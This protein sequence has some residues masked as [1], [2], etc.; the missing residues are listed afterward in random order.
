MDDS[1]DIVIVNDKPE[2]L[3]RD[4]GESVPASSYVVV[5]DTTTAKL[6][7]D[8]L[9]ESFSARG[10]SVTQVVVQPG[11]QSKSLSVTEE[12]LT[13]FHKQGLDR[14]SCVL[15]VGGGVVGDLAGFA[16]GCFMRG[17]KYVQIPT[18]LLSQVDSSVGGKVAVNIP[19]GKNYCGMFLQPQKVYIDIAHLQTLPDQIFLEGL[20]EV[21]K[22][23]FISGDGLY[24]YLLENTRPIL[25]RNPATMTEVVKRCCTIKARIVEKDEQEA[26]KR[27]VLNYGHTFGHAIEAAT[28][29]TVA[30]GVAVAYGMRAAANAAKSWG[31]FSDSDYARH[32]R[33]LDALGLAT[34]PLDFNPT[35]AHAMLCKDKKSVQGNPRFIL[36]TS[37]GSTRIVTNL[38]NTLALESLAMLAGQEPPMQ[39]A[40]ETS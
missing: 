36:P 27:M 26:G 23:A 7:G 9:V 35:Q 17:I 12:V 18:T 13:Q 32:E 39:N 40:K 5:C 33:L 20:G 30:H 29:Y 3:V 19:Q 11:E 15:A 4:I 10:Q 22:Y 14:K 28:G 21:A 24:D 25:E 16:S 1:Y 2:W 31:V 8:R 37:I 38:P 34:K 6:L